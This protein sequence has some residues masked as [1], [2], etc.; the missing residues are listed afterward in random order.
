MG[1]TFKTAGDIM[2][3]IGKMFHSIWGAFKEFGKAAVPAGRMLIDAFGGAFDKMKAFGEA[4]N[5]TGSLPKTF[6]GIA[7]NVKAM[8]HFLGQV[9]AQFFKLAGNKG[10]GNF[11]TTLS[12]GKVAETIGTIAKNLSSAGPVIGKFVVSMVNLISK[13]SETGGLKMFFGILTKAADTVS[14]IFDNKTVMKVFLFVAALHGAT[15]AFGVLGKAGGYIG[16]V[17]LGK[18]LGPLKLATRAFY[19]YRYGAKIA[20]DATFGLK[21]GMVTLGGQSLVAL[22]P[23]LAVVAAI[24]AV[25]VILV[26]AYKKSEIFRKAVHDLVQAVGKQLGSSLGQIQRALKGVMPSFTT[27]GNLLKGIGDFIGKYIV[28]IISW[29]LV[30]L[31]KLIG[32]VIVIFIR[33]FGWIVKNWKLVLGIIVAPFAVAV[34]LIIKYWDN[35]KGTI[36]AAI[37]F[38]VGIGKTLWS[39]ILDGIKWYWNLVVAYWTTIF[40]WIGKLAG[41][42]ADIGKKLWSWIVDGIKWYWGLVVSYW[43]T[44]FSWIGKLGGVLASAGKNV[45]NWLTDFLATRWENLKTNFGIMVDFVKGLGGKIASAAKGMWDGLKNGLGEVIGFINKGINVIIKGINKLIHGMNLVNPGK[46]IPDIP[47]L[48]ETVK[49]ARGGVVRATPGGVHAIIGEAGRNERVEP[50]DANGLSNRDKALIAEMIKVAGGGTGKTP[51]IGTL[52]IHPS[53]QM[54]EVELAALASRRI[55]SAMKR[56]A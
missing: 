5:K 9:I 1:E 2:A 20:K 39:W 30:N 13:F 23:F 54:D 17:L 16:K 12:N 47:T 21:N 38:I 56:G 29:A 19:N 42:V 55:V 35:I 45:W 48:P 34:Y 31:I 46:D 36:S 32:N 37:G 41:I 11:W 49:L 40:D 10:V 18:V 27:F 52:N 33:V 28:P 15:L 14:K 3:Q 8:G 25:V 4:G 26:L 53:P 51:A 6:M 22:G 43:S 7:E 44:I 50:L 24:A